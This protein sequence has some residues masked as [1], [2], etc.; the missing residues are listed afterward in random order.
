MSTAVLWD[1]RLA[2]AGGG[3]VGVS[4]ASWA[5]LGAG[6][7]A[8][9]V[10]TV[11]TF[12]DPPEPA[13][14]G[15]DGLEVVGGGADGQP[16]RWLLTGSDA[17]GSWRVFVV[18]PEFDGGGV[19]GPWL[20]CDPRTVWQALTAF[21]R[22]V[23][24]SWAE[25]IGRTAERLILATHPPAR[26]GRRL[27]RVVQLPE[28]AV[29]SNLEQPY[30]SWARPLT[31]PERRAGWVHVFDA[32]AQYL[33][34]WSGAVLGHGDPVHHTRPQFDRRKAGLWRLEGM[35][36]SLRPELPPV[37]LEGREWFAT[38]TVDRLLEVCDGSDAPLV[39]EAWIWPDQSRYLRGAADR[40]RDARAYALA[41]RDDL[42]RRVRTDA[43]ADGE[44]LIGQLV[45][46]ELVVDMVKSLYRVET[47][48]FNMA[49][50]ESSRWYRP[51]WGHTIRALARCNLH[52]RLWQLGA[53]PFAIATDGLVFAADEPD[54]QRFADRIRLPIGTALGQYKHTMTVP[55]GPVL[56]Q[57]GPDGFTRS[58][59]VMRAISAAISADTAELEVAR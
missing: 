43:N 16:W 36:A 14:V 1:G 5:E 17:A 24:V 32:N 31:G 37:A 19:C 25:S 46:A 23:G 59:Q 47:G 8:A 49:G 18:R 27:D 58:G 39:L 52:R 50:R 12:D 30:G 33:S 2:V 41:T 44:R 13:G 22:A 45:A 55:A 21:E 15:L 4:S 28:P 9:G 53:A 35:P 57:A 38:P 20:G 11:Y 10:D 48:R 51:D 29:V 7:R 56:E 34:A 40:M 54:P 6:C 42:A 26:G 3:V